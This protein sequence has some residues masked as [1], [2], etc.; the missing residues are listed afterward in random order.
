MAARVTAIVV[1]PNR[2]FEVKQISDDLDGIKSELDGGY[3]E[4]L[5]LNDDFHVY[6]D[7]EGKLKSLLP[8]VVA[9]NFV[10]LFIP[11]F[12]NY[13]CI[14]GNIII[15]ENGSM[16]EERSLTNP[17]QVAEMLVGCGGTQIR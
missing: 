13:D 12:P 11:E 10:G 14:A 15:L 5:M 16:G 7:E 2:E 17:G 4:A 9:T 1:K 6:L 3:L 8:N